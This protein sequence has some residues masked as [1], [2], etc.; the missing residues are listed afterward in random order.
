MIKSCMID[1]FGW[2]KPADFRRSWL[3]F[4]QVEYILPHDTDKGFGYALPVYQSAQYKVAHM[5]FDQP[6]D[7]QKL[8][9]AACADAEDPILSAL[10]R[11]MPAEDLEYARRVVSADVELAPFARNNLQPVLAISFLLNKLLLY[12]RSTDSVAIVGRSYA[13]DLLLQ[14][15]SAASRNAAKMK[16]SLSVTAFAAGLSFDFV[17]DESLEKVDFDLLRKFKADNQLL[18]HKHQCHILEVAQKFKALP[19]TEEFDDQLRELKFKALQTRIEME[20]QAMDAWSSISTN[21]AKAAIGKMAKCFSTAIAIS[22]GG[23]LLPLVP[24]IASGAGGVVS[25]FVDV[26]DKQRK[27]ERNEIAYL[28]KA[29]QLFR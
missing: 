8:W 20:E 13:H 1:G 12:A 9:D 10:I 14:K 23:N 16:N 3:F 27:I 11:D 18:F 4:D 28:Y 29:E 25:D 6:S 21:L 5:R 19:D 7:I 17:T 26:A 24:A 2:F 22:Q 15:A